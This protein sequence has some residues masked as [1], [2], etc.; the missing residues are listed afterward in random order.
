MEYESEKKVCDYC[1][2]YTWCYLVGVMHVCN[3][4]FADLYGKGE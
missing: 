2:W 1:E 4:C 3:D